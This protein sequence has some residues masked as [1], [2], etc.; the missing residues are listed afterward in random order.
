MILISYSVYCHTFPNNKVYIG[1]TKQQPSK[2]WLNGK[3]YTSKHQIVMRRAINKYGWENIKHEILH[4]NL[5]EKEAK[6]LET[7]YITQVYHSNQREFGYNQTCGGDGILGYQHS[8]LTKEKISNYSKLMWE[9]EDFRH[10][11]SLKHSGEKNGNYGKHISEEQRKI[12][13]QKAKLRVGDKNPFYGK[14]HTTETKKKIS[15]KLVGRYAGGNNPNA[16]KVKCV[17]TGEIF[18]SVS[19]AA[20]A[21]KQS[22]SNITSACRGDSHT[23]GGYHWE[24]TN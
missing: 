13:S 3:G 16:K 4:T 18:D 23:A 7:Y 12:L 22:H 21:Y 9:R 6:S 8:D 15:K 17:E 20:K 10:E 2:R 19:C 24:Y 14:T 1:I 5:S 11:M